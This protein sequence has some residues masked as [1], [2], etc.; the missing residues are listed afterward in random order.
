MWIWI[1]IIIL[2][3]M[4]FALRAS[5][6]KLADSVSELQR[7]IE[8]VNEKLGLDTEEDFEAES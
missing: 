1:A 8:D 3:V 6:E 5:I 4:Y 7:E 2:F